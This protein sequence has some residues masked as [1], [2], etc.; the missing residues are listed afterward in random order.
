VA[1]FARR[2]EDGVSRNSLNFWLD[3]AFFIALIGLIATGGILYFVLPPGTGHT[4]ALFGLGRH[5]Y[6]AIH[7]Y[8]AVTT[9]G[10]LIAHLFLHWSWIVCVVGK[11]FG[12]RRPS[13]SFSFM[14]GLLLVIGVVSALGGGLFWASSKVKSLPA[15]QTQNA[16][17]GREGPRAADFN[18]VGRQ[19]VGAE[20]PPV[21]TRPVHRGENRRLSAAL[22]VDKHEE[23]CAA[24][25]AING[26][27]SL[28][29]AAELAGASVAEARLQLELPPDADSGESLGRLKRVYG[30][31]IHDVR[32]WA[33]RKAGG[34]N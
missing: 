32:R 13:P 4:L 9:I 5:N 18:V 16:D 25:K 30:F 34:I 28:R 12:K 1:G 19:D 2:R 14:A 7:G 24:G 20:D 8:L 26:R 31:S 15:P 17:H 6:G 22:A 10:I 3:T 23:E 29:R 33:C 11:A 21:D 27:T